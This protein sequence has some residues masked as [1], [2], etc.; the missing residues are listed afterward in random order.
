MKHGDI[1]SN[2]VVITM[3]YRLKGNGQYIFHHTVLHIRLMEY[4]QQYIYG[5]CLILMWSLMENIVSNV[6][7]NYYELLLFFIKKKREERKYM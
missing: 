2:K 6:G 4:T 7:K 5:K 1:P 3:A